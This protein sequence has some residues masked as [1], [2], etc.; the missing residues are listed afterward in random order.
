MCVQFGN[1]YHKTFLKI[2]L[3]LYFVSLIKTLLG[4]GSYMFDALQIY[5][6]KACSIVPQR[7]W[8]VSYWSWFVVLCF[9][10]CIRCFNNIG[11]VCSKYLWVSG[12][13]SIPHGHMLSYNAVENEAWLC[14]MCE[15]LL[16]PSTTLLAG[17]DLMRLKY[18]SHSLIR[19]TKQV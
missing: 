12:E 6:K 7:L 9:C 13:E 16:K 17:H 1:V 3:S 2:F 11:I 15:C 14:T 5:I 19:L 18:N 4:Q 8:N 10:V